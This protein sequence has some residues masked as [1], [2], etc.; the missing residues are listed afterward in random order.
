MK[1]LKIIKRYEERIF[2]AF[3]LAA[4]FGLPAIA[5]YSQRYII[6]ENSKTA[7]SGILWGNTIYLKEYKCVG[8]GTGLFGK[9]KLYSRSDRHQTIKVYL[10]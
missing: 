2:I 3:V 9:Y 6:N 10:H 5:A 4:I 8:E 1:L 7:S